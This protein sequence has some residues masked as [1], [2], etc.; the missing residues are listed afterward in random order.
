VPGGGEHPSHRRQPR[1]ALGDLL[2]VAGDDEEAVVDR[3]SQPQRR[4][5]VEGED[6]DRAEFAGEAEDEEG[7]DDRQAADHQRQDRGD[8]AAEEQQREQE[9]QG[10]GEHLG[11]FQV[12]FDLLVDL[13]LGHGGAA[14]DDPRPGGELLGDLGAGFL[15]GL[16]LGRLQGD[17]EVARPAVAGDE[18]G[19]AGVVV[20]A[21]RL[22]VGTT[23]DA[24]LERFDPGAAGGLGDRRVFDHGED[25]G[26]PQPGVLQLFLGLDGLRGRVIGPV[27]VEAAGDRA[28]DRS[29]EQEE[30]D[31]ED[32]DPAGVAVGK[33]GEGVKH[34]LLLFSGAEARI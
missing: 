24:A 34:Q 2:A 20:A 25:R 8:E 27:G 19:G 22:H 10:E 31:R 21:D 3:Q 16:V 6:R 4:G 28:T 32:P 12:L 33:T 7:A 9:E 18:D 14:D 26:R 29:G 15:P 13:L 17:D 1:P 30:E 11:H 23:A 5:Q